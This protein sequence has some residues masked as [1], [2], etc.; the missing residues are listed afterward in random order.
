MM[1]YDY[2]GM[3]REFLSMCGGY[4]S[5]KFIPPRSMTIKNKIRKARQKRLGR[6]KRK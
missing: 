3:Y 5:A 2:F 6:R 1:Y 4:G